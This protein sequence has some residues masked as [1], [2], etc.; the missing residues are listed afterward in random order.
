MPAQDALVIGLG[1]VGLPLAVQAA[2]AGFQ[3]TGF[4]TSA[5]IAA[6]LNAGRSHV[7]D[8]SAAEVVQARARG[9][10]A[11]SDEAEIGPQDVIVIC[12]PTPLSAADG[13]DLGAVRAAAE[14]AGRLLR[15]GTLV[16][17]ESTTYPGTTDEVVR[18]LLEKTSGLT[19]GI[20]FHL[21]FSPERIDPGNPK[22]GLAQ[23]PEG[24][25]R[26]HPV[27]RGRRRR[28][29]RPVLEQVVRAATAP[30]RRRW[31]SCWRTPTGT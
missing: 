6:G 3:V 24:R 5:E 14:A 30:A 17:L 28:L 4:D 7:D 18:P 16:S 10:R 27:V 12:V 11:T 20:D 23:H 22:Y 2:R 25:R 1:Y 13:P 15:P 8:V 9:F 21:A 31:P 26:R 19:A 29:L